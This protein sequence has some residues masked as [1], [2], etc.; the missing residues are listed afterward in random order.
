MDEK[1]TPLR[2]P[3]WRPAIALILAMGAAGCGPAA[4][5]ADPDDGRKALVA[6]LDAWKGGE[7]PA[8]LAA[9]SPAIHVADGDWESG[10]Q[11]QG[12]TPEGE[13]KLIGSDLNY[14]VALELKNP[15]GKVATR[16]AV[17]AVSTHPQILV[18]RQDD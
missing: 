16:K 13:G 1:K 12:Y 10:F 2:P 15:R 9:R 18:L 7:K 3:A 8:D 17:Y 4:T 11:L 14:T 6:A 5:P